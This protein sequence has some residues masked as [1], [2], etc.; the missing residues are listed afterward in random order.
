MSPKPK[1]PKFEV[2][3]LVQFKRLKR[4]RLIG[5]DSW[6]DADEN[7]IPAGARA[8]VVAREWVTLDNDEC[9]EYDVNVPSLSIISRGWGA[10]AL[11]PI[12]N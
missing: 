11:C 10:Y 12:K 8:L 6:L 3:D 7:F 2:G 4:A 9:W 5:S 1:K